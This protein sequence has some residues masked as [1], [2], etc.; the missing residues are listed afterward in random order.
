[1]KKA[2]RRA[3]Y[4]SQSLTRVGE[5]LYRNGEDKYFARFF[6]NG[7]QYKKCLETHDR[8]TA[9]NKLKEF[10]R[11]IENG[12]ADGPD[13]TFGELADKF[14]ESVRPHLK[15]STY[16]LRS[17]RL[18]L[19]KPFFKDKKIR[20]ITREDVLRWA[21]AR[22]AT[23]APRTFNIERETLIVVFR[24]AMQEL[25]ALTKNPMEF[26]KKRKEIKA[27]VIPPTREQ[28]RE[29]VERLG[30]DERGKEAHDLI[31]FL[32]YSGCRIAEALSVQWRHIDFKNGKL[33][34]TGGERGTKNMRQR[35]VPLFPPLRAHLLKMADGEI[36][37]EA[38]LFT[39][40]SSKTA[41]I[42]SSK[43]MGLPAG[44]HF[45]HHSMRHFFCSNA[46]ES[47]IP[48]HVIAAWLGHQDGGILVKT[49]YG[50]LRKGFSDD[51][52]K[53]MVFEAKSNDSGVPILAVG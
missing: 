8:L 5:N 50:H 30:R 43:K 52:A 10:Q 6:K 13:L 27:V 20:R 9:E 2:R 39:H 32:A 4:G 15:Q 44:E 23:L 24:F 47:N 35:A 3:G 49:T 7:K 26:V 11:E 37:P 19:L 34:I 53:L 38:F 45:T 33:I 16:Y 14:L 28:F 41:L 42:L 46:I 29:I 31:L 48:D 22:S 17:Q 1:M 25:N 12:L 36:S 18:K 40:K 21:T 51:M